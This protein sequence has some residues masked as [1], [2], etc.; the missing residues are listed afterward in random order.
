MGRGLSCVGVR[1]GSGLPGAVR[2]MVVVI[3]LPPLE[4]LGEQASVLD[5]LAFQEAVEPLGV[6]AVAS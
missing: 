5:D 1:R 4:F 3:I 2:A 6:D